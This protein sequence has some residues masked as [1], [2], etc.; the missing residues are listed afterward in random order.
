MLNAGVETCKQVVMLIIQHFLN[1]VVLTLKLT[2]LS[3]DS[4]SEFNTIRQ[5]YFKQIF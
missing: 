5:K 2:S 4:V 3:S 1:K